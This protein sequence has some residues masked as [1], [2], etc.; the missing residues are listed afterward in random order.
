[1]KNPTQICLKLAYTRKSGTAL[2]LNI[3]QP[4]QL[5]IEKAHISNLLSRQ[6]SRNRNSTNL[7]EIRDLKAASFESMH[8]DNFVPCSFMRNDTGF[9][10]SDIPPIFELDPRSGDDRPIRRAT[11]LGRRRVYGPMDRSVQRFMKP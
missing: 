6:W 9:F 3:K 7:R 2:G 5:I 1:M 8:I 10:V 11:E 4:T